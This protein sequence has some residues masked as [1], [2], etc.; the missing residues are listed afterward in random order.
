MK[1][2]SNSLQSQRQRLIA[3][4]QKDACSTFEIRHELDIVAPAPRIY[5]LRHKQGFNIKTF[6]DIGNNPGGGRHRIARYVLLPGKY[7]GDFK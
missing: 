2:I 3:R 1:K 4:L 7:K 6:W 5:E